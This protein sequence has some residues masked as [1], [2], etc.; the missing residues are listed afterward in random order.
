MLLLYTGALLIT[1]SVLTYLSIVIYTER[2]PPM[3]IAY[4]IPP[5]ILMMVVG[6]IFRI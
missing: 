4:P 6:I 3:W 5:A 2:L 1:A